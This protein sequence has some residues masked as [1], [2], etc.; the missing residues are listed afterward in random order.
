MELRGP[1]REPRR[2]ALVTFRA[3]VRLRDEG[4]T[5][6]DIAAELG[7]TPASV[8]KLVHR[9]GDWVRT[10]RVVIPAE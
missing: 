9:W 7:R 2:D 6:R 1:N 8:L 5:Y 10:R 4:L 3:A